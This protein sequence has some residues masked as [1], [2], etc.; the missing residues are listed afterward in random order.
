LHREKRNF[1]APSQVLPVIKATGRQVDDR[2]A[3]GRRCPARVL[4]PGETMKSIDDWAA[5]LVDVIAR[6]TARLPDDVTR[7]LRAGRGQ[8][9]EGSL[10]AMALDAVLKNAELACAEGAPMC[11]D[12]GV[13]IF[14]IHHPATVSSGMLGSACAEA[15]R[16]ATARN[17]L[18]ENAVDTLTGKNTGNG[19]APSIPSVHCE[20]WDRPEVKIELL[21]KGGGCENV[22]AQYS[23]PHTKLGADRNL[24]GARRV[25]LDSVYQAQGKGCG[26]GIL[27][28]CLGGDRGSGYLEAKVQLM[29]HLDDHNPEPELDVLEKRLLAESNQL[30]IGPMGFG[31][32]TT[33]LGVKI[34]T[35]GRV[36][37]SYFVSIA[38]LCWAARRATA[39][40]APNG[41]VSWPS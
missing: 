38:Y 25:I 1:I 3:A 12:T 23:L 6:A 39:L 40:I 36:P 27:G 15:V 28:V 24:E 35:L 16:R 13:P 17:L 5:F 8:E 9:A 11:Q 22:S 32:K 4:D 10:A 7:A 33:V 31:G 30:G 41:D 26:P 29:R 18:R 14:W 37:A 2:A 20:E 21:L 34:G 19:Y